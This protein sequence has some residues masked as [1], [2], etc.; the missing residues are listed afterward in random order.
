MGKGDLSAPGTEPESGGGI[1]LFCKNAS[2][3]AGA[4]GG[5]RVGKPRWL[6]SLMITAGSSMA[7]RMV[8]EPPHWG[9]VVI[10]MAKTMGAHFK[11]QH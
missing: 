11:G 1:R 8:N 3:R 5:A 2:R 6:N 9:Q 7:A 4:F 10:P